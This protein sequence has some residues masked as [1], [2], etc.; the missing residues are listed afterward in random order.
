VGKTVAKKE[1]EKVAKAKPLRKGVKSF[2]R[3]V[4]KGKK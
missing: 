3:T 4:A 1:T 2:Y